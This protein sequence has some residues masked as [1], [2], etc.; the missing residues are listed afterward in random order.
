VSS[1]QTDLVHTLLVSALRDILAVIEVIPTEQQRMAGFDQVVE[2]TREY[3]VELE[4]ERQRRLNAK[5]LETLGYV[6][7]DPP[8]RDEDQARGRSSYE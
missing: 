6:R 8:G 2:R 5:T 7:K 4:V 3:L 1:P